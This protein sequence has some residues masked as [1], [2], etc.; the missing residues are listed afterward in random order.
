MKNIYLI[1]WV[2]HYFF[3]YF[4]LLQYRILSIWNNWYV[5]CFQTFL[6]NSHNGWWWCWCHQQNWWIRKGKEVYKNNNVLL[7]YFHFDHFEFQ[8]FS[9]RSYHPIVEPQSST[10]STSPPT[11]AGKPHLSPN[12][13]FGLS[14]LDF[15][16]RAWART[17]KE[18]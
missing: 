5:L 10:K 15:S 4:S 12:S 7:T 1:F 14:R 11:P 9:Y 6:F 17:G 2:L 3:P 16:G 18:V 8:D 13:F